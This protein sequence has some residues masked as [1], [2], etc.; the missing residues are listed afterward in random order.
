MNNPVHPMSTSYVNPSQAALAVCALSIYALAAIREETYLIP[1]A[2]GF[3]L[4][5]N[6]QRVQR[7]PHLRVDLRRVA[8]R[9]RLRLQDVHL[10]EGPRQELRARV[11]LRADGHGHPNSSRHSSGQ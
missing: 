9:L 10:R 8:R 6:L 4:R 2:I 5:L 3:H 1:K 7:V 11:G